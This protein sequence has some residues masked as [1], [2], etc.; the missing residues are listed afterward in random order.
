MHNGENRLVL[1]RCTLVFSPCQKGIQSLCTAL[2]DSLPLSPPP[3]CP[4]HLSSIPFIFKTL[5]RM[6]KRCK[7][8]TPLLKRQE[9][10][11]P[12]LQDPKRGR[13]ESAEGHLPSPPRPPSFLPSP[14]QASK[15]GRGREGKGHRGG[16]EGW[17]GEEGVERE[18]GRGS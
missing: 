6:K 11:S 3:P 14:D 7:Q 8:N 12:S 16:R 15:R 13:G 5:I 9:S 2:A 1:E 4:P 18:G 17:R 10:K